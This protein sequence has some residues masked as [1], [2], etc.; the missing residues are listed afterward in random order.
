MH[1]SGAGDLL[2]RRVNHCLGVFSCLRHASLANS[3]NYLL[4]DSWEVEACTGED[5]GT[6]EGLKYAA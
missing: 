3:K 2:A 4:A 5:E 6:S 1:Q